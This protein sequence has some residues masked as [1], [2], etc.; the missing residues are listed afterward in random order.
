MES[1]TSSNHI[2][3]MERALRISLIPERN[4]GIMLSNNHL[5]K[6]LFW[7]AGVFVNANSA[8]QDLFIDDE[9]NIDLKIAGL[10]IDGFEI[11]LH[12]GGSY[13]HRI[14]AE[15]TFKLKLKPE[16][17]LFPVALEINDLEETK[18]VQFYRSE[19]SV[20]WHSLSLQG[21]YLI[22]NLKSEIS[23]NAPAIN[24]YYVMVNYFLTGE[25]RNYK[26]GKGSF[27][28]IK[29]NQ[30][31]QC[32][33]AWEVAL[34]YSKLDASELNQVFSEM[35][36]VTTGINYYLNP[37]VRFMANYI[38]SKSLFLENSQIIQ[39]RTQFDF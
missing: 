23:T 28:R 11:L 31:N 19:L 27:G 14:S 36:N 39:F 5:N 4:I 22:G 1:L 16:S 37:N 32:Q 2:T 15:H 13:S 6:R 17:N 24:S 20:I 7:N 8:G 38:N 12:V 10:L 34:R 35:S 25:K 3:F 33:G 9:Y 30:E 18:S 26:R 21:E 29:L